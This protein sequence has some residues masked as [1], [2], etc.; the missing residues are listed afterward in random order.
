MLTLTNEQEP[1]V[2]ETLERLLDFIR[3]Q[4]A[5]SFDELH[6]FMLAERLRFDP[7]TNA[8]SV[9]YF[10]EA[11]K[12]KRIDVDYDQQM[13]YSRKPDRVTMPTW[14]PAPF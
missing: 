11:A 6:E 4:R 3:E 5:V 12:T 7:T 9:L 2:L 14:L 10:S 13:I 8:I 1:S